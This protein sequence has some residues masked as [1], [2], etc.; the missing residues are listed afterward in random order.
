MCSQLHSLMDQ[1]NGHLQWRVTWGPK[2]KCSGQVAEQEL[3]LRGEQ[4][5]SEG[6]RD[7]LQNP[8]CS[9]SPL[10]ADRGSK[11]HPCLPLPAPLDLLSQRSQ[12]R[13][14]LHSGLGPSPVLD[15]TQQ[16]LLRSLGKL[17]HSMMTML[18]P[19]S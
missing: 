17:A 1:I 11:Q 5:S 16:Q 10:R 4:L 15:S 3:F 19:T 12:V 8:T 9:S 2:V 14:Q 13:K 18:P 6:G 7:L